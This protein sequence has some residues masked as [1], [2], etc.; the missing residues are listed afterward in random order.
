MPPTPPN[1]TFQIQLETHHPLHLLI[2]TG[3]LLATMLKTCT[4]ASYLT[5]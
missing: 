4:H 2:Y 1:I 5:L 3:W